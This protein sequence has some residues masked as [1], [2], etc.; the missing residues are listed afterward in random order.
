VTL[1][2]NLVV[3][4]YKEIKK[5]INTYRLQSIYILLVIATYKPALYIMEYTEVYSMIKSDSKVLPKADNVNEEK[6]AE[7]VVKADS[8]A[9]AV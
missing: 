4:L 8:S 9:K 7:P 3:I 2:L 6:T 5:Y 1:F